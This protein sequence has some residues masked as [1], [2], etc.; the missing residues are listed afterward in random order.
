MQAYESGLRH[1]DTR[2]V[3]KP[4]SDFF[5]YFA[6]PSSKLRDAISMMPEHPT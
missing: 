5:R 6:D 1:T 4:D 3:L 2:M